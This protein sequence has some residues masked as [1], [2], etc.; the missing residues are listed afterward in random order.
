MR[1]AAAASS[2][3]VAGLA[4]L[5]VAELVSVA[6]RPEA[7]PVTAVGGAFIDRT[8]PWLKEFAVRNFGTDDKLVL[9]LGILA[10]LGLF[11]LAA[12]VFAAGRRGAGSAVVLVFGVVGA[13][14]AVERPDGH[15]PDAWPSVVGAVVAAGVLYLLAG[16]LAPRPA[17]GARRVPAAAGDGEPA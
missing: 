12:G 11:A 2:G 10:V 14:A 8:P 9:Q 6:V 16:T 5:C 4:A 1:Y 7:S 17:P 3:L 13:W 15:L